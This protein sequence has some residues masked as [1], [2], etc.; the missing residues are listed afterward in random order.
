MHQEHDH[1]DADRDQL[2]DQGLAQRVHGLVDDCRAIVKRDDLDGHLP[3]V[4]ERDLQSRFDLGDLLLEP[5]DHGQRVLAVAHQDD[6]ADR[7][8]SFLVQSPA[9]EL[10]AKTRRGW[11]RRPIAV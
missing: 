4:G 10:R 1:D 2:L 7:L 5:F 9:A 8:S 3:A 11:E 6:A